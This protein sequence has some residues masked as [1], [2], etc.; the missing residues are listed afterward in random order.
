MF[1]VHTAN[2]ELGN[3]ELWLLGQN[4]ISYLQV[5]GHTIFISLS[6]HSLVLCEFL[7]KDML[8]IVN[9]W[10]ILIELNSQQR[11]NPCLTG[12]HLAHFLH[13]AHLSFPLRTYSTL[14]Y[15][16]GHFKQLDHQQKPHNAKKVAINRQKRTHPYSV[17]WNTCLWCARQVT[18]S[19][20]C[21]TPRP[22]V[23]IWGDK[24]ILTSRQIK[25]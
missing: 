10:F 1:C 19:F 21:P 25:K 7:F 14:H 16:W 3:S 13:K 9:C 2:T 12:A 20:H 17:S 6:V 24:Y 22:W 5:A 11:C 23:W 18:Q 8:L 4:W 15:A